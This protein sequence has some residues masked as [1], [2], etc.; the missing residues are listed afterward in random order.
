MA[1][2]RDEFKL[3]VT[4]IIIVA[5]FFGTLFFIAGTAEWRRP[6]QSVRVRF[7]HSLN[8]PVLKPGGEVRCGGQRV[9]TIKQV[10]LQELPALG[11][12][13]RPRRPAT[14]APAGR[15]LA[16]VVTA[17][18]DRA[19]ALQQDCKISADGPTL[20]GSGWLV[21]RDRGRS[22][23]PLRPDQI[24]AGQPPTGLAAA[25]DTLGQ[26]GQSLAR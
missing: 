16:V 4:V 15:E 26:L 7:S 1:A 12:D 25:T 19:V 18:I 3:G 8:L 20:G 23:Q 14:T 5:L 10:D 17:R 2:Q 22:G 24:V 9:G 11:P 13:G 6:T 21:I